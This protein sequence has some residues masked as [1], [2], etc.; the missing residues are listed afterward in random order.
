MKTMWLIMLFVSALGLLVLLFRDRIARRGVIN[1]ALHGIVAFV[2]LYIVN[3]TGWL[4]GIYI[5][6]NPITLTTVG[7]LGVPGLA[8]L[9][10]LKMYLI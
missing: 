8:S 7:V 2:L 4:D 10:F 5:P 1:F 3:V 9:V 6:T